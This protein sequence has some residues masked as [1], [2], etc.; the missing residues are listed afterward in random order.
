MSTR[1]QL[2]LVDDVVTVKLEVAL[3][4]LL[5]YVDLYRCVPLAN[6]RLSVGLSTTSINSSCRKVVSPGGDVT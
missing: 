1:E 6:T 5:Q 2:A 4:R 3:R